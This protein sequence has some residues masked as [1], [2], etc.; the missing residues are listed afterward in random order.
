[1]PILH[2]FVLPHPPLIVPAVGRGREK[3]IAKTAAGCREAAKRIA[4]AG[5]ETVVIFSPHSTVYA[6]YIHISPGR[7]AKGSLARF[8]AP[9]V[10]AAQ[11]DV[12]LAG[13]LEVLCGAEGLPAGTLGEREPELDHG[14]LI[15]LHFINEVYTGYRLIRVAP[16]GLSLEEH[17][18]FGMLLAKAADDLGRRVVV[19]AS[20]DLSHKLTAGGPYGYA[21]EGPALDKELTAIFASGDF[22]ALFDIEDTLRE[23][24]AECGFLPALMLAGALDQKKIAAELCAY[25]GPFGVGYAVASFAVTG[26]DAARNFFARRRERMAERVA[27]IRAGE[28]AYVRLA[29]EALEAYVRGDNPPSVPDGL[30]A[31]MENGRAGVFVSIKKRGQLRGCIGTTEPTTSCIAEEIRRNAVSSGMRDPRFSPVT[32]E[33]LEEL[34]YS[35]DVLSAAEP[36]EENMLDAAEY[37]VIVTGG[38]KRGLLLPNLEGVDTVAVQ[39][40]IAKQKA[41][42][43]DGE[44]YELERFRVERHT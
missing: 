40:A 24:G 29:R 15:P 31:E 12:E 39:L 4:Q 33:E 6:D 1:M 10:T 3:E 8:G 30:P 35:V 44:A 28:S 43:R 18:R 36:C 21:P 42:I 32:P 20:G 7:E 19:V 34:I 22:D 23:K 37:G 5:P 14:V 11:Y 38:G 13:A 25:E 27:D 17:Y 2:G 26:D 41:G 9:E 16:S